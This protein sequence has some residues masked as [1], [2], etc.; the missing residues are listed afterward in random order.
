MFGNT[1]VH[2]VQEEIAAIRPQV[3]QFVALG[4]PC[5][6]YSECSNT[7]QGDAKTPV[8]ARPRLTREEMLAYARKLTEV[9]KWS[10]DQGMPMAYHHHMG[11]I[12]EDRRRRGLR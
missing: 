4:A 1:L 12:I 11:S 9:A 5:I 7:V 6:V 8:N 2:S 3:E 10:A